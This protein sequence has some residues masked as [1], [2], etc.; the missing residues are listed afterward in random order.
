M[1]PIATCPR[2]FVYTRQSHPM[3]LS[4]PPIPAELHPYRSPQITPFDLHLF[5]QRRLFINGNFQLNQSWCSNLHCRGNFKHAPLNQ[6]CCISRSGWWIHL[7]LMVHHESQIEVHSSGNPIHFLPSTI[8]HRNP[9]TLAFISMLFLQHPHNS[10][11]V[12][13][14]ILNIL[15]R[16]QIQ[17]LVK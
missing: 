17:R 13:I 4:S 15:E 2:D 6:R 1:T 16:P 11:S 12:Q 9:T 7:L 10:I 3:S 8:P 5:W 14:S